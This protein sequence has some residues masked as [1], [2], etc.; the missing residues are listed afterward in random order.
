VAVAVH[1]DTD[2]GGD[3]DDLCALAMLLGSPEVEIVGIT[4]CADRDGRRA[5]FVHHALALAGRTGIPVA[6]G[7]FGFLGGAPHELILQD[8]RYWP[9]LHPS[10]PGSA[11][12]ALDLL[13]ANAAAGAT[14]VAI[15]PFTNL[16]LLET[17]RP[18]ILRHAN[19]VVMGGHTGFPAAGLPQWAPEMDYNVQADRIA[20][21]IVFERLDP[22][23][24]PLNLTV[25][26]WLR[27]TELPSLR[28]GGAMAQL[29]ARQ[30]ELYAED[31]DRTDAWAESPALPADLL[32]FQHDPLACAAALGWDC[33]EVSEVPLAL[34]ERG[35][36]LLFEHAPGAK[37]RRVATDVD[38]AAFSARWGECVRMA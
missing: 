8:E 5:A 38:A 25:R 28:T 15:G 27:A 14:V 13:Q 6:S 20:A 31:R 4:T 35:G 33:V 10:Q 17:L 2:I 12:A 11:G 19:L 1:V 36:S 34:V 18:G 3:S 30:A 22:L 16:A 32:N 24:V 7:A 21:R 23:I 9:D 26:A 29:V 37:P